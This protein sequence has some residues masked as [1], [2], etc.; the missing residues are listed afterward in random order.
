MYQTQDE[1]AWRRGYSLGRF[2]QKIK[3]QFSRTDCRCVSWAVSRNMPKWVGH[4]P[5]VGLLILSMSA[6]ILGGFVLISSV[7][8]LWGLAIASSL[9]KVGVSS[10]ADQTESSD[11][12]M[13]SARH[14]QYDAPYHPPRD[15]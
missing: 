12:V 2:W 1:R 9:M 7:L 10:T 13:E 8:I 6:I 15:G 5:I 11:Y 14:G 3:R 4:L